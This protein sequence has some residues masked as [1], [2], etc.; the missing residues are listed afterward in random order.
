MSQPG[1]DAETPVE[2]PLP[3]ELRLHLEQTFVIEREIGRGGMAT[4]WLARR[5]STGDS[6]AIKI[7][8]P[9]LARA[10]GVERFLREIRIAGQTRSSHLVPLESSG[11]AEGLP[12][13]VMPFV[14]GESLRERLRRERQ[15]A[16]DE[17]VR[18]GRAIA[19]G[20][21]ALHRDGIVHRDI[22]PE[23]I[24][25]RSDSEVLVAD[26]G[27]AR[28]LTASATEKITSTG[29]VVGTPAYMS[30]EQAGGDA[31]DVRSDQ[32]SW[33]CI[34]YEM[35][36]GVPPFHGASSQ[37]VMARHMHEAPPSLR[38]VRSSVPE[39]L[40]RVV[41]RAMGKAP[42]DRFESIDA[43]LQALERV[44]LNDLRPSR[45]PAERRRRR[46]ALAA[47]V[48]VAAAAAGYG[49][50][51]HSTPLDPGRVVVFPFTDLEPGHEHEGEQV[52]I[53]IGS[54]LERIE[55]TRW[56][57]GWSLLSSGERS[58]HA[59]L[60][61]RRGAELAKAQHARY[62]LD[63]SILHRPDSLRVVVTLHDL[64]QRRDTTVAAAAQPEAA[65]ADLGLTAVMGLLP[66]LTGLEKVVDVSGLRGRNPA[67]VSDWL[68]GERE[69]RQSRIRPAFEYLSRAVAGDE[70]LAS[71][72][73]R[74]ATAALWLNRSDSA[75][76]LVA[77]ALRHPQSLAPRQ[78]A[79]AGALQFVLTG[80]AD[81]AVIAL[82]RVL[83]LDAQWPDAWMLL[84]EV[85]L[86][87]LPVVS[88]DS[89]ALRVVPPPLEWPLE[90]WA[91]D[92]FKRA[93]ALDP[94]FTPPLAHLAEI[95]ARRGDVGE[96]TRYA[97]LLKGANPDSTQLTSM[98]L[99]RSCLTRA[100]RQMD[101]HH[102]LERGRRALY[103]VGV[104]LQ[105]AS[106]ARA[107]ACAQG[108]FTAILASDP[109]PN[110]EDWGSLVCL[111]ALLAA[112]GDS[113]SALALTDSAVAGGLTAA[114]GLYVVD[115]AAGIDPGHRVDGFIAQLDA[116]MDTRP[117]PSL[118][119]L[120]LWSARTA[121]TARL[122]RVAEAL[123][124]R[125][126][127]PTATRLDSL[128]ARVTAA[129]L[130]LARRDT[131]SALRLFAALAPSGT[132]T[133]LQ[134]LLWEPLAPERLEYVRLLLARGDAAAA[135]RVASGFDQPG[136]FVHP[137]FLR[138]SLALRAQAARA[139]H[140]DRLV[141]RAEDRLHALSESSR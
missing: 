76:A 33:G 101:W 98:A 77:A 62:Y 116:A 51:H 39:A 11:Q 19:E 58:A 141:A 14:P 100:P 74:G 127:V 46:V 56:L 3:A 85:D 35:L 92:A 57:D 81:S 1:T 104:T 49:V 25:L 88:R 61:T 6:V 108:A 139:L 23:N 97:D 112:E 105:G 114:L 10:L 4:V 91:E 26:Y 70:Q 90:A 99:L 115:A 93:L 126:A 67:A 66:R 55:P 136:L 71:A 15:L 45:A 73:L 72:A 78:A 121:D 109:K 123:E 37:A 95:A 63:G 135:H 83:A 106:S 40:E 2:E 30:P 140:D 132:I 18:I 94:G 79:F 34:Q 43:L 47:T 75:L 59:A 120:T 8:Q 9:S 24:L 64:E 16:V 29:M 102:E 53:L 65:V 117:A 111:H 96:F 84:G 124:R 28:A 129:Y 131:T 20:L 103:R 5:R 122:L 80:K 32:Y 133:G 7:L 12:Y 134:Q 125:K 42:A 52:T 119:L 48:A 13:Y 82:R 60:S 87:L 44:D 128:I 89:E 38:V 68:R 41:M 86:H 31:V 22:K 118:W 110:D 138:Q 54:A 130:T 69:Y 27:I 17:A 137:L 36:A 50:F 21:A 107:R 113:S